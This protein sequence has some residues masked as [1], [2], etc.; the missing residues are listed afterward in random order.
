MNWFKK[1]NLAGIYIFFFTVLPDRGPTIIGARSR[2]NIGDTLNVTC[3]SGPSKPPSFL[4]WRVNDQE[5]IY[6][7]FL[8]IIDIKLY[9]YVKWCKKKKIFPWVKMPPMEILTI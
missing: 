7:I 6:I 9:L 3:M 2:Y 4:E 1:S 5:V 8:I